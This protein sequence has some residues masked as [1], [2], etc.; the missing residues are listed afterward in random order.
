[1]PDDAKRPHALTHAERLDRLAEIGVKVGLRLARGQELV[2]TASLD[3]V[4]V[5]AGAGPPAPR[6]DAGADPAAVCTPSDAPASC[7]SG[8]TGGTSC[9]TG[10]TPRPSAAKP[11]SSSAAASRCTPGSARISVTTSVRSPRRA[12]PTKLARAAVVKPFLMPRAPG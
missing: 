4:V 9:P 6:E 12:A 11:Q 3:A 1:M 2:L 7:P 5:S 8:V 10:R